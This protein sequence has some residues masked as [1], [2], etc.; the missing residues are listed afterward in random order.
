MS[1]DI[2]VHLTNMRP[3][4]KLNEKNLGYGHDRSNR[5]ANLYYITY[6]VKGQQMPFAINLVFG[7]EENMDSFVIPEEAKHVNEKYPGFLNWVKTNG[8]E[9]ADWYLHPANE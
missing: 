8:K 2:E 3:T 1:E 7:N 4:E 5:D 6:D 9:D